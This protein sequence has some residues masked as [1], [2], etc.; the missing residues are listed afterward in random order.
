MTLNG[1]R[2]LLV[3]DEPIIAMAVEDMLGD[4]GCVVAGPALSAAAAEHLARNEPLDAA[5]LDIN[6]GDG[7]SFPIAAILRDRNIPFVFATGYGRTGV[8]ADL[9]HVSVLA[10]PYTQE[11][12]AATLLTLFAGTRS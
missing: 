8:P 5:L 3:E 6:M 12:L 4:L 2:V 10:K 11:N 9:G 7:A 1:K